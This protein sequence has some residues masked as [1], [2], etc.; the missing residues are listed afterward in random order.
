MKKKKTTATM[1]AEI[2]EFL[3]TM[4]GRKAFVRRFKREVLT[5]D[6]LY[7]LWTI[8]YKV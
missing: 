1:Q 8:P 6:F 2:R 7:F 4:P 5:A 3:K